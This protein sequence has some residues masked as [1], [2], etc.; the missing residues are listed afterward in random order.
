ML[1]MS[2]FSIIR[3]V[4]FCVQGRD[5]MI[6]VSGSTGETLSVLQEHEKL[7]LHFVHNSDDEP[8]QPLVKPVHHWGRLG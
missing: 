5:H 1:D 8:V 6:P 2:T 4:R 3:Q 7:F